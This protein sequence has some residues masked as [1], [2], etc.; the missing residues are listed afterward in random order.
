[1]QVKQ[2]GINI[3]IPPILFVGYW[4]NA[5]GFLKLLSNSKVSLFLLK[6]YKRNLFWI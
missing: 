5:C 2:I 1:M 4:W 3:E 6:T